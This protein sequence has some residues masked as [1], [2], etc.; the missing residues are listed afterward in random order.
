MVENKGLLVQIRATTSI[1]ALLN[2]GERTLY[3]LLGIGVED[4]DSSNDGNSART[5]KLDPRLQ[6]GDLPCKLALIVIDVASLTKSKLFGL[7]GRC[8]F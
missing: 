8:H 4:K 7:V 5:S 3:S 6:C 1:S 2:Q